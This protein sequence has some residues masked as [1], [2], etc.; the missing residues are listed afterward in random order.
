MASRSRPPKTAQKTDAGSSDDAASAAP[1][2]DCL[3]CAEHD[4]TRE[5]RRRQ[6]IELKSFI[7]TIYTGVLVGTWITALAFRDRT[8][9]IA[10][11]VFAAFTVLFFTRTLWWIRLDVDAL[12]PSAREWVIRRSTILTIFLA[13][14][15]NVLTFSLD[16]VATPEERMLLIVYVTVAGI[17]GA[18]AV[19]PIKHAAQ[20]VLFTTVMPYAL[21]LTAVGNNAAVTGIFLL[22]AATPVCM[23]QF[24]RIADLLQRLTIEQSRAEQATENTRATMRAF[25]EM[26]SDWAWET[27]ANSAVL[28]ISP[29]INELIG[30]PAEECLG[31]PVDEV[32][33]KPFFSGPSNER[34]RIVDAYNNRRDI[35]NA[36]FATIDRD[37][38]NRV[39]ST[40]MRHFYD[41][42]GVYQGARAWTSDITDKIAA[43]REIEATNAR[44]EQQVAERTAELRA[45]TRLLDEIIEAMANGLCVLDTDHNI[46]IANS[47]AIEMSGLR[48]ELWQV[49]QSARKMMELGVQ[50]GAYDF[51]SF[52][53]FKETMD[54]AIARTGAFQTE[55]TQTDGRVIVEQARPR[56]GGGYVV[57]YMDM[58]WARQREKELEAM[59]E[60]L[61]EAKETAVLA[62]TAKSEFLANMSHEIRTPMNGVIGM[63]SLLLDTPLSPK[64]REMTEVIV[65]SGD[66][67]LTIINDILD[68]SKLEAGK[69][70]IINEPFDL[71]AAI[72]DVA[73]L[74]NLRVQ[75][76]GIELMVRYQPNLGAGFIG[77]V[78]R[79]RQVI[80]N[81][82]GNAVK[83]TEEGHVLI[84]VNGRRRGEIADVEI[85]VSDTGCG[86]PQDKMEAIFSAFEQVDGTSAR[87]HD[88]TGLGLAITRRL[89][90]A[91]GGDITATSKVGEGSTFTVKLSLTVDENAPPLVARDARFLGEARVLVLDDNAVNRAILIEQ[92]TAWGMRPAAF[93]NGRE[94]LKAALAAAADKEPFDLAIVDQQ[95]PGMDGGAF[96][97]R[98]RG[99]SS[100]ALTP[101][102]LL[103]SAGMKGD[104]DGLAGGLFDAYLVKPARASMLLD[105]IATCVQARATSRASAAAVALNA[106]R[107]DNETANDLR[108]AALERPTLN[109]LV[110]EDNLVNQLVIKSILEKLNC[111]VT[112]ACNGL[113]A[114]ERYMESRPDI[115]LMDISMP[116]MDGAEASSRLRDIQTE[117]NAF[118]PIVG[119]TAHAMKEDRQR[120]LDA[121]M[122]DYLPKPVKQH[123]LAA[124]L[125]KW[126]ARATDDEAADAP[127]KGSAGAA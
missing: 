103:T 43:R 1:C 41:A 93:A 7:P 101:M 83:F 63:A 105:A 8:P 119:V 72:D 109:V 4:S 86:V 68:F 30:R 99:Q 88:G 121:G 70:R 114:I 71:R 65:N 52:E 33:P 10:F 69:L 75:E 31:L 78:G 85:V 49:G 21:Y 15:A 87:R 9:L 46:I 112:I 22:L 47:K 97:E 53:D 127:S 61:L 44:L 6:L 115:I 108:A 79:L 67:L 16:A 95:M 45:R 19:A 77:D 27:D 58:T 38:R 17:G 57:N 106:A 37:G 74:L 25:M 56:P 13:L 12:S 39:L 48:K 64:Q 29:R 89:V 59:S 51:E 5:I 62:S 110:A 102:I 124:V 36:E 73:A 14:V 82:V 23:R 118:T 107:S 113:E 120:C 76:K 81:L 111:N 55:R 28:Y 60:E 100:I 122:D 20:V 94:A 96:A 66:N 40:T 123:E 104:P 54:N 116:E 3:D 92:T 34:D 91:M 117:E 18:M 26:A 35:K 42:H 125:E 24:G 90:S 98:V 126:A 2:A 11:G 32:F 50:H 84:S 80:T